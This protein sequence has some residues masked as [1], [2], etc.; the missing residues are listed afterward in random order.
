MRLV[1]CGTKYV[2]DPYA[3]DWAMKASGLATQVREVVIGGQKGM[4]AAGELWARARKITVEQ[5]PAE[6]R[7]HGWR[8]AG[9][10]RAWKMVEKAEAVLVFWDGRKDKDGTWGCMQAAFEKGIPIYLVD[11]DAE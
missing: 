9:R 8:T 3:V 10:L 7:E 4:N 2:F 5:V 6:V 11:Y 1:I